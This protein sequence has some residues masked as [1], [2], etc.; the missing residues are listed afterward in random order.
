MEK[1]ISQT[2]VK[3]FIQTELWQNK[4]KDDCKNGDV[5]WQLETTKLN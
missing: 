5:F 3:N 4:L 1:Y 2:L